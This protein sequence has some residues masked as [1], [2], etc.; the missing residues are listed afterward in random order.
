VNFVSGA[1]DTSGFRFVGTEG[2]MTVNGGVKLSKHP[3]EMAPGLSIDTF[4]KATQAECR[5]E[6]D[7]RYP[8]KHPMAETLGANT[9]TV[10]K[11]PHGYSDHLDHH[12]NFAKAIRSR[13]P[14]VEDAVFGLRAAGPALLSNLS[15]FEART[16]EWDPA[17]MKLKA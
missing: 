14:V 16:V 6:Y 7:K 2:I 12:T 13:T 1:E 5:A 4:S 10:F 17:A 15:Y 8:Q 3:P 9:E 11:A